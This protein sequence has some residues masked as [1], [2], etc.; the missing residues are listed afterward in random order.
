MDS[1]VPM[2]FVAHALELQLSRFPILLGGAGHQIAGS[3]K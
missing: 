3:V 1:K 2:L